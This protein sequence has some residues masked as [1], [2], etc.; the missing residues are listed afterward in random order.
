LRRVVFRAG[1]KG[2]SVAA[3]AR[4]YRLQRAQVAQW[5][6]VG[7]QAKFRPGQRIVLMLPR[8]PVPQAAA[9]PAPKQPTAQAASR[10]AVKPTASRPAAAATKA[11]PAR[12]PQAK[13]APRPQPR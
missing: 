6:Q 10:A 1:R 13:P 8:A 7:V 9:G 11:P 5:N 3:V 2:D 4:R 12:P